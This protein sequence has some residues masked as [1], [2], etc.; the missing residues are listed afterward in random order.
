MYHKTTYAKEQLETLQAAERSLSEQLAEQQERAQ[1]L[2]EQ[3]IYVTT[4]AY[5][6]EV[7]K[8]LGLVYPDEVIF[9]AAE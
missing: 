7:A 9:K 3:R 2:E 6:E 5:V 8:K 1:E 4:K